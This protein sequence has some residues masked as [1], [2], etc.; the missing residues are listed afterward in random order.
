MERH[1]ADAG[2]LAFAKGKDASQLTGDQM[3]AELDAGSG[4][5]FGVPPSGVAAMA[6]E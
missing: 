2:L 6:A 5:V 4:G 3:I 1:Y